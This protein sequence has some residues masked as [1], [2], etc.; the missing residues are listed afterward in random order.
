LVDRLWAGDLEESFIPEAEQRSWRWLKRTTVELRR[1]TGVIR[2]Q[3]EGLLEE[4]GH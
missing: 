2:N 1:K 4:G 3:V